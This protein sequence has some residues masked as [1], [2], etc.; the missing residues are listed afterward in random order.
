MGHGPVSRYIAM[1][2]GPYVMCASPVTFGWK[3]KM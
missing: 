3:Y 2:V 1:D